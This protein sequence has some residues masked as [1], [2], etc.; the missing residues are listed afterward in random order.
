MAKPLPLFANHHS[1]NAERP[2]IRTATTICAIFSPKT[3]FGTWI[4]C[5]SDIV[6]V[7]S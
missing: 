6:A 7:V 3:A 1:T 5:A 4:M 2:R